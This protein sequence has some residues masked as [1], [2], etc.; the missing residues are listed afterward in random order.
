MVGNSVT[1]LSAGIPTYPLTISLFGSFQ[2]TLQGKPLTDFRSNKGRALLAYLVMAKQKP[3]ARTTLTDLLWQ[4][5]QPNSARTN[6]RQVLS[7]LRE[8]LAPL[9]LIRSDYQRIQ[10][11]LDP[12]VVWCD[13]LA[14]DELIDACQR[15]SHVT[16]AHCPLCQARLQQATAL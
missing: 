16:L 14:F 7:N 9:D 5:Y 2:V 10:L 3:V 11:T 1:T 12:A 15:H 6:L 13:V 8:I 4:N